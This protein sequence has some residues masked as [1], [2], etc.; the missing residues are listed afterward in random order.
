M[1]WRSIPD[2]EKYKIN[3]RGDIRSIRDPTMFLKG[4]KRK[5]GRHVALVKNK[6]P[7][8]FK[9]SDLVEKVFSK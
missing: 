4:F 3:D 1:E 2:F 8:Y 9:V 7:Y 5:S 6:K